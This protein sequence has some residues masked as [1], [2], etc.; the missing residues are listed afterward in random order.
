MI[1]HIWKI[2][3]N[4]RK[5]NIGVWIELLLVAV[6]MWYIIDNIYVTLNNYYKPLGFDTEHTYLMRLGVLNEKNADFQKEVSEEEQITLLRTILERMR[7]N[8]MIEAASLSLMSSPHLGANSSRTL[9]RDTL[10]TQNTVLIRQVTP[11]FFNV[12]KYESENGSTDELIKALE[13]NELVISPEVEK[14]LFKNGESAVGKYI[15]FEKSDSA[16]QHRVGAVSTTIRYDNFS[17]WSSYFAQKMSNDYLADIP[18]DYISFLEFCVRV[19]PA[20]DY[21]FINRF[22]K[23]MTDQL[24]LGNFFLGEIQS[25]PTNKKAFQKDD[26]NDLQMRMFVI[27]FLLINIF[28]GITG[29]FWFRT[30]HRRGEIGLRISL[31]DMPSQLL[32]KFFVEGLLLLT[33][34]M[35]PAMAIIYVL[36]KNEIMIAYL[37]D[38]N[39]SRYFMGF[40]I[41]YLF[42]SLMIIFGIWF[43]ARKAIKISPADALRDE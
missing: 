41:T 23:E 11:D 33:S 4:E 24:R 18:A 28:L 29:I 31:G 26:M 35:I 37:M 19:K 17:N 27:L 30:Q 1:K 34:A 7:R 3:W 16:E 42:L 6:F 38:F 15:S 25:I 9:Y 10:Q 5:H 2:L 40:I 20:E 36:G 14:E 39:V 8:P 12:F 13:R 43:P 21:D 22:R 32:K